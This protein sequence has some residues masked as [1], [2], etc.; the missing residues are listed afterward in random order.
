MLFFVISG[1][2]LALPFAQHFLSGGPPVPLGKYYRRRLTRLEPPYLVALLGI[3]FV[4]VMLRMPETAE[5]GFWS[6]LWLRIGYLFCLVTKEPPSLNGVTWSLEIEVQ[7]Y[8]L[9]PLFAQIFRVPRPW[10]RPLL[11][12]AV[13]LASFVAAYSPWGHLTLLGFAQFFLMGLLLA[14]LYVAPL[15]T[16]SGGAHWAD[17]AGLGAL[18][19]TAFLPTTPV[20]FNLILPWLFAL[21]FLAALRGR[22]FQAFLARP[23][24]AVTGGM[25]YS[26]YLI[27]YPVMSFLAGKIS[28][29]DKPLFTNFLTL[30][31]IAVPIVLAV[32]TVFYLLLERPCMDP[33]WPQKLKRRLTSRSKV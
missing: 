5:P 12:L 14:D 9:S 10:R 31:V 23:W 20:N 32:G 27:H 28:S 24:V 33:T 2:I 11:V 3:Y 30:G 29:A 13:V 26:I 22:F 17:L 15:K 4:A 6:S 1:F 7:F 8:L 16:W 19:G 21:L 18:L 25:C